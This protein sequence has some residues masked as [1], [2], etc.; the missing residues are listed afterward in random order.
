ML[1]I[2]IAVAAAADS[3]FVLFWVL[4]MGY[5]FM[6]TRGVWFHSIA[7]CIMTA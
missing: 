5:V 3:S 1:P 7:G 2:G 6:S 4:I